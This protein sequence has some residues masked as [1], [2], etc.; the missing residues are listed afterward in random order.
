[1]PKGSIGARQLVR[2]IKEGH[3]IGMLVDQK[4]NTGI[5]VPFFGHPA[6]TAPAIA[7]LALKYDLPLVPC[8]VRRTV[9]AHFEV[10]IHA[11]L[12]HPR[13]DNTAADV[14]TLMGTINTFLEDAIRANPPHWMWLH[15]RW[16]D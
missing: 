1:V 13:T 12:E 4:L 14:R 7:Q 16:M 6:M 8:A 3:H 2:L 5:E 11:P 15:R 10:T 9:G